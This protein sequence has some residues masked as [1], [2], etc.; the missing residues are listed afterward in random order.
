MNGPRPLLAALC[1]A[2]LA[3]AGA[4]PLHA[5]PLEAIPLQHRL[6][7]DLIPVL[8]PL[9]PAG[10]A[11]TGTGNVLLVRADAAT[12]AQLRTALATLD[13]APRQLLITVGQSTGGDAREAGVHGSATVGS[14]D[15]QVGVNRPPGAAPGA[16][17][18]VRGLETRSGLHSLA[19]VRTVEGQEAYVAI[20]E[21]RPYASTTVIGGGR[22]GAVLGSSTVQQAAQTG[23]YATP[24]LRGDL[25][26]LEIS[27]TQQQLG[28]GRDEPAVAT[29]SLTT[30]V[31]G[32][33]GEWIE[34]GGV[35]DTR[36]G[37]EAGL[38]RWGTRSDLTQY[39]AWVKVEEIR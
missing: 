7:E 11:L 38:I 37:T 36:S 9:L 15:V 19:T 20:G 39:S 30:T 21:T 13:R 33:L 26:V 5:E 34:L 17:V 25:V 31:S 18:V 16:E 24:R 1:V 4:S 2:W 6:A 23:F 10:A 8:Q 28:R 35:T 14:G 22:H 27:P 3:F 32:R 12:V 29:Q